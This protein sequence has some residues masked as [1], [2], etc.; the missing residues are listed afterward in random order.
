MYISKREVSDRGVVTFRKN[1][2]KNNQKKGV[3]MI[4][5]YL[6]FEKAIISCDI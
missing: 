4:E 3:H 1:P 2:P 5:D 6:D